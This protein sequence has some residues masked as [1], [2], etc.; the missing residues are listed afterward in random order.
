MGS[1]RIERQEDHGK[2]V[3][4]RKSYSQ[5]WTFEAKKWG[6]LRLCNQCNN[7]KSATAFKWDHTNGAR[8]T[9]EWRVKVQMNKKKSQIRVI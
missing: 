2:F 9:R 8:G 6:E 7:N 1:V 3:E 4:N 5:F